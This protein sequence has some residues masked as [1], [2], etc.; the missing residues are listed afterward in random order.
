MIHVRFLKFSFQCSNSFFQWAIEFSLGLTS[1]YLYCYDH[2]YN[3]Y[4][5]PSS[6]RISIIQ[7]YF[8][9]NIQRKTPLKQLHHIR[10]VVIEFDLMS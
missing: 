7:V 1:L 10:F 6:L 9:Y 3:N 2:L 8:E 4:V 5:S